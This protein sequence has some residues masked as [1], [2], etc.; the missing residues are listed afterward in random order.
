MT[1][2]YAENVFDLVILTKH[3]AIVNIIFNI[4]NKSFQIL[5]SVCKLG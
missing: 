4:F 2:L 3:E 5:V 1:V